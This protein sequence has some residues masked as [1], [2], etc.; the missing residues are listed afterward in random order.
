VA[1]ENPAIPANP[2][3]YAA[4]RFLYKYLTPER[5]HVLTD[6]R[7]RFTQRKL[8]ED[9]REFKPEVQNLGTEEEVRGFMEANEYFRQLPE[10]LK[11]QVVLRLFNRAGEQER[12][13]GIA[14]DHLVS[15]D[16]FVTLCLSEAL[17]SDRMWEDYSDHGRGFVIEF[18]TAHPGFSLLTQ[19]GR[20]GRVFYA[21][22]PLRTFLG[23]YGPAAFFRKRTR[24]EFEREWRSIRAISQF[25]NVIRKD[26][27]EPVYLSAFDPKCVK[28]IL[29]RPGSPMELQLRIFVSVDCRYRHVSV[30]NV[31]V[32][33]N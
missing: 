12:V 23:S 5:F 4:P 9:D 31:E 29:T 13:L 10:E 8:F 3:E 32:E 22:E 21:D 7:L 25:A 26:G 11:G 18:D 27:D 24:Y 17:D 14:Q 28:R 19:P 30:N 20:L 1:A 15:P 16:I 2:W 33:M 6:C